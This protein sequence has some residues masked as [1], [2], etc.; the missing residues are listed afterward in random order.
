MSDE[1]RAMSD[2]QEMP[3]GEEAAPPGVRLMALIRWILLGLAALVALASWWS[4]A[5][6]AGDA[7]AGS[8]S[9]SA[10]VAAKYRCPMHPQIVSD[11]PGECPICHMRLELIVAAPAPPSADGG[12]ATPPGTSPIQLTLDRVQAIGVRTALATDKPVASSL[13]V[14][15]VVA[16]TEQGSAEVH[17][18]S[19]G[20]VERI[21]VNQTGIRVARGQFLFGVYSPEIFQA[22]SE[23]LTSKRWTGEEGARA[24]A[25]ATRKLDLLGMSPG[26]IDRVARSGETIRAVAVYAP[27]AGTV[28][29]KTV[30]LGSYAT[31]E[32][33]LYEIQD[34]SRVY[35]IAD[36]FQQ[37]IATL[38]VGDAGTFHATQGADPVEARVDLVYPTVAADARTTRVRMS[39]KNE[40][41]A[42]R[43]GQYGTV[44]FAAKAMRSVVTVP[45]DAV[46]DTGKSTYVFMVEG[47]AKFTPRSITLGGENG[48]D[49]VVT[50]GL[51]AGDRVVS[52]ATF[53]IDSE[54]RL[55]ASATE[56]AGAGKP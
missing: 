29:K 19:P 35:V 2:E 24:V 39:V 42:L 27:A 31:P 17:V 25:A 30:V 50:G 46:I 3:E 22:Q 36:V 14:T 37:D 5:R 47:Q 7:A 9:R 8:R 12:A 20:F 33:T 38:H 34:L 4:F 56:A 51:A 11:Q 52:G 1:Q 43:P 49:V 41:G 53:L 55:Q 54:S 26:D 16:P 10:T 44:E 18:R 48:N 6:A 23:L 28:M 40:R 32:M 13:R 15:A 45:R 21:G